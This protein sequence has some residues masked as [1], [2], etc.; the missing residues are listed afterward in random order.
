MDPPGPE[1]GAGMTD[2]G[3][4]SDLPFSAPQENGHVKVSSDASPAA[5]E[6]GAK[7]GLGAGRQRP[8]CREGGARGRR[9]QG[10]VARR[11]RR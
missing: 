10:G 3:P 6:P 5:A 1:V 2:P 9:E 4:V 11:G 8:G 7:E